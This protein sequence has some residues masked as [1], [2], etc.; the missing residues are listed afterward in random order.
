M[1]TLEL[2][3]ERKICDLIPRHRPDE[4][5]EASGVSVKDQCYFLVFDDRKEIARIADDLRPH[6]T[7]GLFGTAYADWGY[8]GITYNAFKQRFYLLVEARKHAG[9]CYKAVIVEYDNDFKYLKNRPVEFTFEHSNKGFEAIVHLRRNNKDYLLAL[10]EGNKCR[11][12]TKGRAADACCS[13]RRR[14][15]AGCAPT[16]S[17][18]PVLFPLSII[19]ACL[20]ITIALQSSRR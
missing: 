12:G 7:N 19:R 9:D 1:S 14:K 4:R 16:P 18:F 8:E 2:V 11:G 13:S 3:S 17:P 6:D 10:C 5:W 20:S 15:N